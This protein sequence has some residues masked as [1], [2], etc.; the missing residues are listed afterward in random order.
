MKY[1]IDIVNKK[2]NEFMINVLKNNGFNMENNNDCIEFY[3]PKK[4]RLIFKS[5]KYDT[6]FKVTFV[7]N[8]FLKETS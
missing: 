2:V 3:T 5:E 8:L 1:E 7:E 6:H 4:N